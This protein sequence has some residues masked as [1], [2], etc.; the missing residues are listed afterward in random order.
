MAK[1]TVKARTRRLSRF[2]KE[3]TRGLT[4][5]ASDI[6]V[7]KLSFDLL[8]DIIELTP[9]DTGHA[10]AGWTAFADEVGI[11]YNISG[12]R[13][14]SDALSSGKDLSE[15]SIQKTPKGTIVVI[16][17]GVAYIL[18]LEFGHSDQA[19]AGMVRLSIQKLIFLGTAKEI[20]EEVL[21]NQIIEADKKSR[22]LA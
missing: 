8:A 7:R 10:R 9:V 6:M 4:V 13:V 11:P 19:P 12:P 18:A 20:T 2:V 17:N 1:L 15:F 5:E 16:T 21:K 14:T 3:M 22:I